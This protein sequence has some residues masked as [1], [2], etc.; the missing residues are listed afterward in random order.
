MLLTNPISKACY[1]VKQRSE[2]NKIH[3]AHVAQLLHQYMGLSCKVIL[4]LI[5]HV[6]TIMMM[7]KY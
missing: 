7:L 4:G 1:L 5:G 2:L 6:S 3:E